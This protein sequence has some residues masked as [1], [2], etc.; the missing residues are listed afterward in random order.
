[1]DKKLIE[2]LLKA[3]GWYLSMAGWGGG[4]PVTLRWFPSNH[5]SNY[6]GTSLEGAFIIFKREND[7]N[8]FP[9]EDTFLNAMKK[10]YLENANT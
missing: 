1:M 6:E 4:D 8:L 2:N 10:T 7:Y 9:N 3:A 5:P